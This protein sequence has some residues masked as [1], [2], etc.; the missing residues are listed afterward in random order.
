MAIDLSTAGVKL[1]YSV[2]ASAGTRPTLAS[3]FT[4]ITGLKEIPEMNPAPETLETTT[5]DALEYKTYINGLKDVG[6]AL[7]FT[8]N[9][10]QAFIT[11][12]D[13]LVSAHNTGK[14]SGKAT[15]FAIQIPGITK[16]LYFK[17]IPAALGMPGVAV[18]AVLE[19]TAYITPIDQ[20][21]WDT[22]PTGA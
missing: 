21:I 3:A 12:W 9:L 18:N 16:V 6:G 4:P 7:G 2:E 19:H 13:A 20:L 8:V 22:A 1:M 15:W 17:G 11:L 14:A 10:T 5:L